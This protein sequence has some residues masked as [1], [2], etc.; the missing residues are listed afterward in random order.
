MIDKIKKD[1]ELYYAWQSNI[2]MAFY[3][4]YRR[5][6]KKYKNLNDIH[7]IANDGAKNFL[8]LLVKK[9][10]MPSTTRQTG[11]GGGNDT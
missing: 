2:A 5:C 1:K 6:E 7:R 3:D 9:K 10:A 8:N 11:S 4:E